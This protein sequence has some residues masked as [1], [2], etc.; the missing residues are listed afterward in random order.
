MA[1]DYFF[2]D[3]FWRCLCRRLRVGYRFLGGCLT[4]DKWVLRQNGQ[5]EFSKIAKFNRRCLHK[6]IAPQSSRHI[7]PNEAASSKEIS[8]HSHSNREAMK[9]VFIVCI[10]FMAF[11][12]MTPFSVE[13]AQQCVTCSSSGCY[14]SNPSTKSCQRKCFTMLL[15]R[16]SRDQKPFM[17]KGCTSD[18]VFSRRRCQPRPQGF[19]LKWEK[20]WGRGCAGVTTSVTTRRKSLE[21]QTT[22]CASIAAQETTVI[23]TL[24]ALRAFRWRVAS[25][26]RLRPLL[27]QWWNIFSSEWSKYQLKK[28]I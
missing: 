7:A 25:S 21:A 2:V 24:Q 5:S 22:T 8:L 15:R 19:S 11:Y 17:I 27:W 18:Q 23:Q 16:K 10:V 28:E 13:A 4:R 9:G 1:F 12:A 20:P 6:V 26:W 14:A 3:L